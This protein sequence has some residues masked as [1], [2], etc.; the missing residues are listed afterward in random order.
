MPASPHTIKFVAECKFPQSD[1]DTLWAELWDHLQYP[2]NAIGL[3]GHTGSPLVYYHWC[4][5]YIRRSEIDRKYWGP[6][7]NRSWKWPK[8]QKPLVWVY[9]F[10]ISEANESQRIN[11]F[12]YK[13][14]GCRVQFPPLLQTLQPAAHT[15]DPGQEFLVE[16]MECAYNGI[17]NS[18]LI[19]PFCRQYADT[20]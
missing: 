2:E 10:L 4:T 5:K 7:T 14:L 17:K 8:D 20:V 12:L 6:G 18:V 11:M 1:F 13:V 19:Y 16:D 15:I 3:A 9:N